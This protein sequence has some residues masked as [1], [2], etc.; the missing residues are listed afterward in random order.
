MTEPKQLTQRKSE[1][2]IEGF[3]CNRLL[4][5]FFHIESLLEFFIGGDFADGERSNLI[6]IFI[7]HC[8]VSL[9]SVFYDI[10]QQPIW[11][12]YI[13]VWPELL[14]VFGMN[15]FVGG[16]RSCTYRGI[17]RIEKQFVVVFRL[18]NPDGIALVQLVAI[19]CCEIR[20][21]V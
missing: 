3:V 4:F 18:K 8:E 11:R 6:A 12:R 13:R 10:C 5:G 21:R 1:R 2:L 17:F 9:C 7:N 20:E 15:R 19:E 14:A 16:D